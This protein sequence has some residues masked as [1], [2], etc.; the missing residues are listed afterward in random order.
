MKL[1]VDKTDGR[2]TNI[3]VSVKTVATDCH[4]NAI[5][6]SFARSHGTNEV[7]VGDLATGRDLM[8]MNEDHGVVAKD[9]V[10]NGAG[11]GEA[12]SAA[13][14][15]IG[16]GSGPDDGIRSAEERVDVF[17]L[18]S[19]RIVHFPS[20]CGIVLDRLGERKA[21]MSARVKHEARKAG[22]RAFS[23]KG[24]GERKRFAGNGDGHPRK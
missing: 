2:R 11:F 5:G 21:M 1:C 14:P 18:A 3:L 10:A 9:L 6:L 22:A 19:G 23:E 13:A 4:A 17:G 8:G 7:G 15:F 12:L 16:K 24:C 20:N